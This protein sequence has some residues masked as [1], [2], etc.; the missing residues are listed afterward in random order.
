MSMAI[1]ER[2]GYA[3]RLYDMPCAHTIGEI[4]YGGRGHMIDADFG[5][6]FMRKSDRTLAGFKEIHDAWNAGGGDIPTNPVWL[7]ATTNFY[8][9]VT[10]YSLLEANGRQAYAMYFENSNRSIYEEFKCIGSI[11]ATRYQSMAD[12]GAL[13]QLHL[14]PFETYT[15]YTTQLGST[16]DYYVPRAGA[17]PNGTGKHLNGN[18]KWE[19]RPGFGS[20]DYKNCIESESNTARAAGSPLLRP[21]ATGQTA[22]ITFKVDGGHVITSGLITGVVQKGSAGDQFRIRVSVNGG[23]AWTDVYTASGTG[24][25]RP[26]AKLIPALVGQRYSYLVRVEMTAASSAGS[27][28]LD[29]L[30]ITTYT[31]TNARFVPFLTAGTNRCL[32]QPGQQSGNAR[33]LP[34]EI[35]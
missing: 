3:V 23:G 25:L 16:Q 22:T 8:S 27:V 13:F 19:F 4:W 1:A 26:S 31:M 10:T 18:G 20:D 21:A 9:P 33:F 7:P 11:D 28:G 17:N 32:F 2:L 24:T 15:I 35:T 12:T 34:V 30:N 14:K 29:S 5:F 6:Y